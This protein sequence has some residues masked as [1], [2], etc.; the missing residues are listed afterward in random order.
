MELLPHPLLLNVCTSHRDTVV[1]PV[2]IDQQNLKVLASLRQETLDALDNIGSTIID[3]RNDA[4]L[5]GSLAKFT[6]NLIGPP[7]HA[8]GHL[9]GPTA[10]LV[11]LESKA[12][13]D[14][15]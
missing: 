7:C 4:N 11:N 8:L 14:G 1:R 13:H 5:H 6:T 3:R 12:L 15:K 10:H 2:V 9:D